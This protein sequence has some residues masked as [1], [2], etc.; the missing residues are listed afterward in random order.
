LIILF[1]INW[2][3][4]L[5]LVIALLVFFYFSDIIFNLLLI[6]RAYTENPE[7]KIK[8]EI[9]SNVDD[10]S[11]PTYSILCPL[12]KEWQVIPQFINAID[13]IDYPKDKLQVLLLLE[14]DDHTTIEKVKAFNLPDYFGIEIIP[15][16]LPK[17]KPKACN[18]GLNKIKG[19]YCVIYDAED[20]PETDQLKKVVYAFGKEHEKVVCIQAKLNYYNPQQNLLTKLFTSEYSLWF[21]LVLPGLQSINAPIPLGGTSNHFRADILKN[22]GGWDPFNVTE[23][24]DLGV[25]LAKRGYKTAIID[26]TTYEEANSDLK[27]W[28]WQRTRWIKGYI[29]TYLVHTRNLAN[30]TKNMHPM[31]II[32]FHLVVGGKILS[33]FINPIMWITTISYFAFRPIAGPFIEMFFPA[34]VLYMG[35]VALVF[36]N[37]LY[38]YYYMIGNAKRGN[39]EL[40]KFAFFVPFYW[41]LMSAA[42]IVAG[43][44]L[45]TQPFYWSKTKHGLHLENPQAITIPATSPQPAFGYKS[46][47]FNEIKKSKNQS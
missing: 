1:L 2:Q 45:I 31:H 23:D 24:C 41:I 7:V 8:N 5:T 37:F 11:L 14:E 39:Y 4:S 19:D 36:G 16:S 22:L 17:T 18:F 10:S 40:I 33:M 46:A 42:A 28:F 29:Q 47:Y 35:V 38:L 25:R 3:T 27:N 20:I 21:D 9:I 13:N 15:N 32:T 43:Y 44:K 12:Y 6:A 30:F 26:S 34:P